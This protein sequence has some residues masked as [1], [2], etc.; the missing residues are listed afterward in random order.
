[1]PT[2]AIPTEYLLLG[3]AVLLLL[4]VFG[5]KAAGRIGVPALLL[6]LILGMLAGSD[7]PGGIEFDDAWMAQSLGVVAL[8]FILFAGGLD[9]HWLSA[10]PVL[11]PALALST[12]GVVLTAALVGWFATAVLGFSWLEGLLLG[13]IISSTDAA[14][15]FGVLSSRS[16]ALKGRLRPLLE[17]ESGSNDP[18]AIFL[19][20]GLTRLLVDPS[21]SLVDL[22]PMF[23]LQ[24]ALGATLGYGMGRGMVALVNV[25][26]LEYEGLYSVLTVALVLLTYGVAAVLGGNGFLAVYMAG[27]VMGNRIFIHKKSLRHFHNGLAWLM[28]ITMFFTLGLLV[29]PS[30]LV[31]VAAVSLV[32][33]AFLMFVAR[34]IGVFVCLLPSAFHFRE[35]LMVAWVGL[36]GAVPIIL[37]TFPLLAGVPQAETMF[38]VVF[39]TVLTSVLLQGTSLPLVARWL[40]VDAPLTAAE[41]YPLD[42]EPVVGMDGDLVEIALPPNAAAVGKRILEVG[43]PQGALIVLLN[44]HGEFLIPSGGTLLEADDKLLIFMD[45]AETAAVRALLEAEEPSPPPPG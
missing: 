6:F 22:V 40:R 34:P 14:A 39:F 2:A 5:S 18:M 19:T 29:F 43:L 3:V 21:A 42:F 37:A 31:P 45:K 16:M 44:R 9:T 30:R 7:G 24:M 13:A 17:L 33:A 36:R 15:V 28:Q 38:N 25:V 32:V 10:R 41:R 27:L 12:L 8:T 23:F 11:W 35:Q 20:M 26:R 1:M 4:S